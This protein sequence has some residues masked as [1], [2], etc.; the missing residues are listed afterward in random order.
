[1]NSKQKLKMTAF[2]IAGVCMVLLSIGKPGKPS[3]ARLAANER[4]LANYEAQAIL[5]KCVP[6][7][8]V[9]L[10]TLDNKISF[11]C[12]L[13]LKSGLLDNLGPVS[14]PKPVAENGDTVGISNQ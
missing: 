2:I 8:Q 1:M 4:R 6:G 10:P 7:T 12:F 13:D 11:L 3:K 5:K 14:I 9:N